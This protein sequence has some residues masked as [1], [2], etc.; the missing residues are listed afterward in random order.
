MAVQKRIDRKHKLQDQAEEGEAK[1]RGSGKS[2]KQQWKE[3]LGLKATKRQR[4]EEET[5]EID[6]ED[7]DPDY[8]PEKDREQEYVDENMELNEEDTFKIE[9]LQEAGDYIVEIRRFVSCFGKVVRKAKM[10]V[11]RKYRKLIH[12]M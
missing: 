11:G 2:S 4:E 5:E 10:D 7:N 9:K 6:D 8:E 1:E 12:F 3:K